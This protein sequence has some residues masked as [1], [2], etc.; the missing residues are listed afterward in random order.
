MGN[1]IPSVRAHSQ[2]RVERS[3]AATKGEADN[4]AEY[5]KARVKRMR[6][7]G[8]SVNAIADELNYYKQPTQR[9]GKWWPKTVSNLMARW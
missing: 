8:M 4:F 7:A 2:V 3:V 6:D 9:G 1:D 5:M